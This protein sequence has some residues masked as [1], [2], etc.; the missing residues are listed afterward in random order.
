[1]VN[2]NDLLSSISKYNT[3][4]TQ[5]TQIRTLLAQYKQQYLQEFEGDIMDI[6]NE[7][8]ARAREA[9]N[10]HAAVHEAAPREATSHNEAP[11]H[12][13]ATSHNEAPSPN[14]NMPVSPEIVLPKKETA[15]TN[16]KRLVDTFYTKLCR[17]FHPDRPTGDETK[18]LRLQEDYE[19]Q[20]VA[21]IVHLGLT[22]LDNNNITELVQDDEVVPLHQNIEKECSKLTSEIRELM[23]TLPW[24]WGNAVEQE[25][26]YTR[27]RIVRKL[28][29]QLY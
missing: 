25:R 29:E 5:V 23:S 13:E 11:S 18:F 16:L 17:Q 19:K 20:N 21:G 14:E 4:Y 26:P 3:I 24:I 9:T 27:L 2:K 7:K 22:Q 12:N 15:F 28:R 6:E 8:A 10:A 1:M